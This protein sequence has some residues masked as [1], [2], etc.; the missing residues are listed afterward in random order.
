M[1][2]DFT[3]GDYTYFT[4]ISANQGDQ[5]V[6]T[7]TVIDGDGDLATSVQTISV[8]DGKPVANDD[9]DTL[10]ANGTFLE[11]NVVTGVG[12]DAG[13]GIGDQFTA[14]SA[15]GDGVDKV[16]DNAVVNKVNYKG[17]DF[18]LGTWSAGVYTATSSASGSGTGYTYSI[19]N[20]KLTWNSTTAAGQQL[21]FDD[22]GYYKYTPPAAFV[23]DPGRTVAGAAITTAF[24]SAPAGI[25]LV[26]VHTNGTTITVEGSLPYSGAQGVGL[27]SAAGDFD[28]NRFDTNEKLRVIFDAATRPAGV[29]NPSFVLN[30][31]TTGNLVYTVYDTAGVQIGGPTTV[32]LTAVGAQTLT[33]PSFLGVGSVDLQA[34][35]SRFRVTSATYVDAVQTVNLTSAANATAA[36]LTLTGLTSLNAAAAVFYNANGAG[37]TGAGSNQLGIL[38]SLVI[39]FNKATYGAGVQNVSFTATGIGSGFTYTVFGVDGQLLGRISSNTNAAT[40]P[41]EYGYIGRIVIEAPS[42]DNAQIRSVKFQN[43]VNTAAAVAIPEE[44]VTYTLTDSDG[45]TDSATLTLNVLSNDYVGTAA[46]DTLN[47]SAGN[48]AIAGLEGNDSI[49]GGAGNDVIEGGDGD[50]YCPW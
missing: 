7:S 36:G 6:L 37:V 46:G 1:L 19:T 24:T 26:G 50:E 11:G 33:L 34:T 35:T 16:L 9:F 8:V 15:S 27:N 5:F 39:Q 20:G 29:D 28:G 14:F 25:T 2:F 23:P 40:I 42:S 43:V 4:G 47:G 3:S 22:S 41:A 10:Q 17:V 32:A 18:I 48:D 12:T 21:I 38:E 45:D 44:L 49:N 31:G 30:V 13:I